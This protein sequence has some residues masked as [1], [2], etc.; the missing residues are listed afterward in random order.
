MVHFLELSK[1]HSR[2]R[3]ILAVLLILDLRNIVQCGN[4]AKHVLKRRV[5]R[6]VWEGL[7]KVL[8]CATRSSPI[9]WNSH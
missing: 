6:Q 7:A 8:D 9:P 1:N 2:S 3:Q 4:A 5:R